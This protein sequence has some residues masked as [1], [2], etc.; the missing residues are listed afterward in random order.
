[1]DMSSREIP[2]RSDFIEENTIALLD[3]V[4]FAK[5]N[6]LCDLISLKK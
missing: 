5:N 1:M 3:F 4:V 6:Y 2:V